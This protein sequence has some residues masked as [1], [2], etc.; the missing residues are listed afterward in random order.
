MHKNWKFHHVSVV[1]RD[2]DKA[3][4]FYKSLGVGPFPPLI[5]PGGKVTLVNKTAMGK[6]SD[7][8]IDLRHAEGGIGDLAFEVI[9]PLDGD[10][11]VKEFLEKKGEG[12]QHIGFY[13]DDLD[14]E[15]AMLAQKGFKISQSGESPAVKWAYFDTDK[16]GG[17]SIE[18]M[19]K[20]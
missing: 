20:K 15:A 4:E 18:L 17:V 3:M 7:Y 9:Q 8:Q 13:V 2:M 14:K 5:G 19:Q 16:V 12:I 1:V 11:P 6:A 10:T